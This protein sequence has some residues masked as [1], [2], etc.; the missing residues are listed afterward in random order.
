MENVSEKTQLRVLSIDGGGIKGT[1]PLFFLHF[2]EIVTQKKIWELFD[3]FTGTSIGGIFC[4]LFSH[5]IISASDLFL[6]IF[7][8]LKN[9]IFPKKRYAGFVCCHN[10][11]YE[12]ES[13]EKLLKELFGNLKFED[14]PAN[15]LVTGTEF[16]EGNSIPT[17][18]VSSKFDKR[19]LQ[20]TT[21]PEKDDYFKYFDMKENEAGV[22]FQP[23]PYIWEIARIT[24]AAYP[25][26]GKYVLKNKTF[27]DGGF[28][29]NNPS[30]LALKYLQEERKID[31]K[32]VFMVSLACSPDIHSSKS[33]LKFLNSNICQMGSIFFDGLKDFEND[34]NNMAYKSLLLADTM[35][36]Q[37]SH[38][39]FA[40]DS[41]RG[42][43]LDS[44]DEESTYIMKVI[45]TEMIIN[46]EQKFK[47]LMNYYNINSCLD[48]HDIKFY[49]IPRYHFFRVA[50]KQLDYFYENGEKDENVILQAFKSFDFLEEHKLY[51]QVVRPY[52]P[53][54]FS[55]IFGAVEKNICSFCH[56]LITGHI[57]FIK[58]LKIKN[59][60]THFELEWYTPFHL[61]A[62]NGDIVG[63]MC[64]LEEEY[65][66]RDL[67]NKFE[68]YGYIAKFKE[69]IAYQSLQ[70][71]QDKF[72]TFN[73]KVYREN[74][75]SNT[76]INLAKKYQNYEFIRFYEYL[77]IMKEEVKKKNIYY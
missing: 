55:K 77:S 39:R 67:F 70:K 34:S 37:Y 12:Q 19:I 31:L 30:F 1:I 24:S 6:L 4:L 40:P 72:N 22:N 10:P 60:D 63:L 7:G 20:I 11:I 47:K 5:K 9:R 50:Y 76:P 45:S 23:N 56:A 65:F 41:N 69:G 29:Y 15:F 46:F 8:N 48:V 35:I 59:W 3:F 68:K 25:I 42:I 33:D 38:L 57:G 58:K 64:L 16:L 27:M 26:L 43:S 49:Y 36:K 44:I 75:N 73:G 13:M 61:S 52:I 66:E 74:A 71:L 62:V 17:V 53:T 28:T 18:F 54:F 32:D 2:L 21:D 14:S 51:E